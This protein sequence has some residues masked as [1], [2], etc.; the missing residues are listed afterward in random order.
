M[1]E[2]YRNYDPNVFV[3]YYYN[4][5]TLIDT[6]SGEFHVYDNQGDWPPHE[7]DILTPEHRLVKLGR[8]RHNRIPMWMDILEGRRRGHETN[9][10]TLERNAR[11]RR[12][13]RNRTQ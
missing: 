7:G 11:R 3:N 6:W 9:R 5:Q 8:R 2:K 4:I 13:A 10:A 12:D 1:C